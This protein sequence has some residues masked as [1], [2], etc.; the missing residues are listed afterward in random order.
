MNTISIIGRLTKDV[1]VKTSQNGTSYINNSIAVDRRFKDAS[2]NKVTDFFDIKAFGKTADFFA[3]AKKGDRVGIIGELQTES[4]EKDGVK[5]TKAVIIVN[6]L[7]LIEPKKTE[8]EAP[9]ASTPTDP[10]TEIIPDKKVQASLDFFGS[11]A[12][13][14]GN[15][16]FS[17]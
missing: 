4:W 1:D 5:R 14:T 12:A 15:L 11:L 7:D 16:P 10:K 17:V 8:G 13:D 6:N 9:A 2:G 3:Y